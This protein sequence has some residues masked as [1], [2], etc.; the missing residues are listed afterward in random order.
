MSYCT[1]HCAKP[2]YLYINKR[3]S[4][5]KQS[6]KK[7]SWK[8]HKSEC[9]RHVFIYW[10]SVTAVLESSFPNFNLTC[11]ENNVHYSY[12]WICLVRQKCGWKGNCF[13]RWVKTLKSGW[14]GIIVTD[15]N[16][17]SYNLIFLEDASLSNYVLSIVAWDTNHLS[18]KN[19]RYE[20]S[21]LSNL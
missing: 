5:E 6:Q 16:R 13:D 7:K 21:Y 14:V 18:M 10:V 4:M 17:V 8:S 20:Q 9:Q 11:K 2:S 19:Y 3:I 12:S 1:R 15:W